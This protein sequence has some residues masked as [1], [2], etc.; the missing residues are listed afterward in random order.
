VQH[1]QQRAAEEHVG[2]RPE[3]MGL[4]GQQGQQAEGGDNCRAGLQ[5]PALPAG[6]R[7][8]SE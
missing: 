2:G 3:G 7:H 1:V 6:C 8:V 4:A 5:D